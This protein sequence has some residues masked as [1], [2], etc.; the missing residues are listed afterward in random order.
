MR[1]SAFAKVGMAVIAAAGTVTL[2]TSRLH[3]PL[4][5]AERMQWPMISSAD[6]APATNQPTVQAPM[7]QQPPPL[8][9]GRV[10][11]N[12]GPA[13]HVSLE[14]VATYVGI[15]WDAVPGATHYE[16][17]RNSSSLTSA[18]VN[19]YAPT[20][21]F[22]FWDVVPDP[23]YSVQYTV[24]AVQGNN[25]FGATA[26]TAAAPFKLPNPDRVAFSRTSAKSGIIYWHEMPGALAYRIDG[27]T[28]PNT[29]AMVPG[30]RVGVP[31]TFPSP[32]GQPYA[33]PNGLQGSALSFQVSDL[34]TTVYNYFT[35]VALYPGN[36]ADYTAKTSVQI[37]T[38]PGPLCT[39][40][41]PTSGPPGTTVM[42]TG[43]NFAYGGP[44]AFW[45]AGGGAAV[46][47][48]FSVIT[49]T[50]IKA[51]PSVSARNITVHVGDAQADCP[52]S[53]QIVQSSSNV[54]VPYVVGTSLQDA[55]SRIQ[56]V[57]LQVNP[58]NGSPAPGAWVTAQTP[59]Y[60]TKVAPG[61]S[62]GV[63]TTVPITGIRAITLTNATANR[64]LY[65]WAHDRATDGWTTANGGSSLGIGAS[66]TVNLESGHV[67]DI[68]AADAS[69]CAAS[70][71]LNSNCW[72]W[73]LP[74][75][76]ADANGPP[77]T[78]PVQF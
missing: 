4:V 8:Q 6:A 39:G 68:Y 65:V 13:P 72:G 38:L 59:P 52:G 74:P 36:F 31:G 15:K 35:I 40:I 60:N 23:R 17:R 45:A 77:L 34:K 76:A 5:D 56:Q 48:P 28:L 32:G 1:R 66:T 2:L 16:L 24:A 51:V 3:E 42:I 58:I 73:M 57:G 7:P 44:V 41:S 30:A 26:V 14:I 67:Y 46:N 50:L 64:A 27:G 29:G 71:Y 69:G 55:A 61:S 75:F 47:V 12:T 49:S 54:A 63:T 53:F 10:T 70:D 19:P 78:I 37:P 43:K 62:V 33:F 11:C 21:H 20:P 9:V 22:E 25:C 18:Q